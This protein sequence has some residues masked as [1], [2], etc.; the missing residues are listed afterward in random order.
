MQRIAIKPF[1]E[2]PADTASIQFSQGA[3]FS[4]CWAHCGSRKRAW[5]RLPQECL[6]A[7]TDSPFSKLGGQV[8]GQLRGTKTNLFR[9]PAPI[10]RGIGGEMS[11]TIQNPSACVSSAR[12]SSLAAFLSF[13]KARLAERNRRVH[14]RVHRRAML[15]CFPDLLEST[16]E[17]ILSS[18][19][20]LLRLTP[21]FIK[22]TPWQAHSHLPPN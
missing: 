11:G 22:V 6:K 15:G 14:R 12:M 16:K 10:L 21:P 19:P 4:S 9:P 2:R 20:A 18:I 3:C 8:S 7:Q 17:K 1:T 13:G 5:P